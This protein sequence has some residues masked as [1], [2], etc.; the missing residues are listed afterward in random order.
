MPNFNVTTGQRIYPATDV[1]EQISTAGKEASGTGNMKFAMNG[2]LTVGTMDGANIELRDE[3]GAD[4]FFDFGLNTAEV[5]ALKHNGYRP[6]D[7]CD[8]DSEL[9]SVIGLIR[10]GLFSRGDTQ[11][12]AP[13]IDGL[14]NHDPYFVLADFRSYVDCQQRVGEAYLQKNHWTRMS[15]LNCARSGKFSSDRTIREYC[16]DIWRVYAT[17]I[18]LQNRERSVLL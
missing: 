13:L 4:N 14:L 18:E 12:F 17:P 5:Q 10:G 6:A 16:S 8:A 1:S 9:T 3:V 11:L 15:I 7:Y 2:A